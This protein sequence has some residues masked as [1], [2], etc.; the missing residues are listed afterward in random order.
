MGKVGDVAGRGT[1]GRKCERLFVDGESSSG[2][3]SARHQLSLLFR[4]KEAP[5]CPYPHGP[6]PPRKLT[7]S[8]A[9]IFRCRYLCNYFSFHDCS[10]LR[11]ALGVRSPLRSL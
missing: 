1:K 6:W 2:P 3:V 4:A 9:S 11:S 8:P 5:K 10:F 7:G